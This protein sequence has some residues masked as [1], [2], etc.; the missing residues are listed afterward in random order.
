MVQCAWCTGCFSGPY[1]RVWGGL[2]WCRLWRRWLYTYPARC[3][4]L[5]VVFGPYTVVCGVL[6][7]SGW[8]FSI[9]LSFPSSRFRLFC[10][11]TPCAADSASFL[12]CLQGPSCASSCAAAG[13]D[14]LRSCHRY[15]CKCTLVDVSNTHRVL[16]L[17]RISE[18]RLHSS[19]GM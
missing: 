1:R 7:V 3:S 11:R 12:Q 18:S 16:L 13:E 10:E 9:L 4:S 8:V 15:F 17:Q 5:G 2:S 19:R 6:G 14:L